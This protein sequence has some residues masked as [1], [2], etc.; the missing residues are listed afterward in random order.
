M[1]EYLKDDFTKSVVARL[2]TEFRTSFRKCK[3][4]ALIVIWEKEF[5]ERIEVLE[6]RYLATYL[7]AKPRD[8]LAIRVWC[9]NLESSELETEDFFIFRAQLDSKIHGICFTD[10]II[11]GDYFAHRCQQ[12]W[13]TRKDLSPNK[14]KALTEMSIRRVSVH[15]AEAEETLFS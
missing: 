7:L 9:T 1:E 5:P 3:K 4:P 13:P 2:A 11:I 12:R 15:I 10:T 14:Y 8:D 6:G